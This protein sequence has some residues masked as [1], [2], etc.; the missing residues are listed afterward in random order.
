MNAPSR[1]AHLL[2]RILLTEDR[3]P[4]TD[5]ARLVG[6]NYRNLYGRVNGRVQFNPDEIAQVLRAVPD[7]RLAECLLEGT[8]FA[9]T[10]R[11]GD[12]PA[13]D[14]WAREAAERA[15]ALLATM[16]AQLGNAPLTDP[17]PGGAPTSAD[18]VRRAG[19][20]AHV[21]EATR[22]LEIVR[23]ALQDEAGRRRIPPG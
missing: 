11:D 21:E 18:D 2:R 12:A 23:T 3:R 17:P 15:L 19:L 8:P 6:M 5:I 1:F 9:A 22:H 16:N 10:H 7:L 14:G 20:L 13:A 4:L